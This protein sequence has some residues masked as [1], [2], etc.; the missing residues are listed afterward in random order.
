MVG[1]VKGILGIM[2]P[3]VMQLGVINMVET[4]PDAAVKDFLD[5]LRTGSS[6]VT[7][8][9]MENEYV[10]TL[11]NVKGDEETV[12]RMY[13]ALFRNFEYTIDDVAEKDDLAVA[14]VSI[15]CNDF[16]KVRKAYDKASCK[17]VTEHLYDEK[18][19]D[20]SWLN[21]KCFEIYVK[22]IENAADKEPSET[23]IYMPLEDNGSYGWNV[24]ID[25]EL[26]KTILGGLKFPE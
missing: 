21:D 22:Q 1:I 6:K 3:L 4:T 26:M 12:D 7:E 9:Y 8:R 15:K 11:I 14:K 19:A 13:G 16:T 17:Y 20:K 2:I 25:D 10:N 5:G 24:I 23:V 18:I